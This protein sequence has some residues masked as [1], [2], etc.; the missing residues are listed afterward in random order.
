MPLK[1]EIIEKFQLNPAHAAH[2]ERCFDA[3]ESLE[4]WVW[5]PIE[6]PGDPYAENPENNFAQIL[7]SPSS[8]QRKESVTVRCG[9]VRE[10]TLVALDKC[11]FDN[12]RDRKKCDGLIFQ[13][14]TNTIKLIWIE[15]KMN[16]KRSNPNSSSLE[17][18][19][20][21]E[22]NENTDGAIEQI[23]SARQIFLEKGINVRLYQNHGHIGI[24]KELKSLSIKSNAI[25]KKFVNLKMSEK[26]KMTIGPILE[27]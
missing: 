9:R 26:I 3:T 24:P 1:E 22:G 21:G 7:L 8:R 25:Q 23:L 4:F 16:M 14:E 2:C 10:R 13:Q 20:I 19:I 17:L 12:I 18:R 27:I 6:N 15:L 11:I 5:D